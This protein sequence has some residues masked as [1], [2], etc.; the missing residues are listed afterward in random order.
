MALSRRSHARQRRPHP[1]L[2][3]AGRAPA[4][5][6]RQDRPQ[7]GPDGL[8]DPSSRRTAAISPRSRRSIPWAARVAAA[9]LCLAPLG[10]AQEPAPAPPADDGRHPARDLAP[11]GFAALEPDFELTRFA[12]GS[13]Y[14]QAE[15]CPL[16]LEL[17]PRGPQL[18]LALGDNIYGDSP[19]PE[20]LRGAYRQLAGQPEWRALAKSTRFL[21]TWDDHDYGAN[22]AGRE[23]PSGAASKALLLDFFGEPADSARRAREGLYHS[24][25]FG[26]PERRV[27]VL[28][29]DL[30]SFRASLDPRRE[31]LYPEMGDYVPHPAEREAD[32]LGEAQWRWL[33]EQLRQPARLRFVASSTQL[34]V[35]HNGYEAWINYPAERERFFELVRR[36]RAEGLIVLSGDTHYAELNV[37]DRAGLYPIYDLTS[38][39]LNQRWES[40]GPS[41]RRL[42]PGYNE[43]NFGWVEIR[44]DG[45]QPSVSLAVYGAAGRRAI[46]LEVPIAEL[47]FVHAAELDR[48]AAASAPAWLGRWS[49][50][51]GD[52]DLSAGDGAAVLGR[53]P[54]GALELSVSG[55]ALEGTWS[56]GERGGRCRFVPSRDGRFLLGVYGRGAGPLRLAWPCWRPGA[57]GFAPLGDPAPR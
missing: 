34:V 27:Q 40:L 56:E 51:F 21:A 28:L 35:G 30:R 31:Q 44:W 37:E 43:A 38:S 4:P 12:F 57:R 14:Q 1:D 16:L 45:P 42:G 23:Y 53:T 2:E 39:A 13:C 3:P 20:V 11:R 55:D 36:T 49:S 6:G 24:H 7:G 15:P 22:D 47:G 25:L 17:V 9:G 26:P 46:A 10:R 54:G 5:G 19:D 52:L 33:E 29:L 32:F 8:L 18:Y 50:P 41:D 48:R